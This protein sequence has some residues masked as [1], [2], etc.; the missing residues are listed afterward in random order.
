LHDGACRHWL[1][2]AGQRGYDWG[3]CSNERSEFDGIVRFEHDGCQEFDEDP[4]G[5]KTS[6]SVADTPP[7]L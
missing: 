1:P 4:S 5:W 3:A 6:E 7:Q 2:L